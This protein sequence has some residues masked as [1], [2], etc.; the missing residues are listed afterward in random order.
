MKRENLERLYQR[1]FEAYGPQHWWPGESP[2]EVMVGAV[3][4]Q[5]TAW[6]N[7][8]KAID[9]LKAANCLEL[10]KIVKVTDRKLAELIRP[11]GYFNIK[12]KRLKNLCQWF[13]PIKID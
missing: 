9:N 6:S 5:N 7:V 2:F 12:T 11:S 4:T 10:A 13:D 8:E 3:L 1:L